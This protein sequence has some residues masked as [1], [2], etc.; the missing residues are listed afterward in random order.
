M[1]LC[2]VELVAVLLCRRCIV[3]LGLGFCA[4]E[5]AFYTVICACKLCCE[6]AIFF[7]AVWKHFCP[8]HDHMLD[9]IGKHCRAVPVEL[10]CYEK[11]CPCVPARVCCACRGNPVNA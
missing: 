8:V 3:S 5:R 2:A 7:T 4:E 1:K 9:C 6:Q 11:L 10:I